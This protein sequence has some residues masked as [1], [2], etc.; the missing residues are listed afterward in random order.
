MTGPPGPPEPPGRPGVELYPTLE[1][2]PTM[3]R[4]D[5][6]LAHNPVPVRFTEEDFDY[7]QKKIDEMWERWLLPGIAPFRL[8]DDIKAAAKEAQQ[9]D[10]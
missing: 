10:A 1:V 5:A 4:T 7:F 6:Y 3:P 2:G 9:A 8:A